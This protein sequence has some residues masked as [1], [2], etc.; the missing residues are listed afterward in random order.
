VV[1]ENDD[2]LTEAAAWAD[3]LDTMDEGDDWLCD[4]AA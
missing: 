4:E 2:K 3:E 1:N